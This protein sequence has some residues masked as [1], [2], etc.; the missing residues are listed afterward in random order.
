MIRVCVMGQGDFYIAR[1][2]R[3]KPKKTSDQ[4]TVNVNFTVKN[5][6]S[7][8]VWRAGRGRMGLRVPTTA[9]VLTV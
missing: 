1:H 6:S 5:K 8:S 9:N 7:D 2:C 3:T 4:L